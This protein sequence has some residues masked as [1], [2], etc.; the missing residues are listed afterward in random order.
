MII[1]ASSNIPYSIAN[2]MTIQSQYK[3]KIP[4]NSKKFKKKDN[5]STT[6][7]RKFNWIPSNIIATETIKNS[8]N[9]SSWAR[10]KTVDSKGKLIQTKESRTMQE[11][12]QFYTNNSEV[13]EQFSSGKKKKQSSKKN[14]K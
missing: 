2:T 5:G 1:L 3:S 8:K 11:V 12:L 9:K 10:L 14:S 7:F 13:N 6:T 4:W